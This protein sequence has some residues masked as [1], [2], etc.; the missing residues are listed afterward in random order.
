MV[1]DADSRQANWV[2][3]DYDG[4]LDLFSAQRSG[5]NR[6]FRNDGGKFT[7]VSVGHSLVDP[8]RTAGSCWFDM[9]TDH[10]A[11][12]PCISDWRK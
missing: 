6:M 7:D 12:L 3:Y 11:S 9:A 2:D 10:R 1:L 5:I 4:E 8:R